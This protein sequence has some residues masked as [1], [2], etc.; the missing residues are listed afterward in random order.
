[1]ASPDQLLSE[2]CDA[3]NAGERPRVDDYLEQAPAGDRDELAAL[4]R[5]FLEQAPDA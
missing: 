3:W 4:I 1:M 2:F 5:T